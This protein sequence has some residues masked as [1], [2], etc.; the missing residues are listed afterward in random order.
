MSEQALRSKFIKG[1]GLAIDLMVDQLEDGRKE[2]D[3]RQQKMIN[4][5]WP[6]MSEIIKDAKKITPL[7]LSDKSTSQR[8]DELFNN[9]AKGAITFDEAKQYMSLISQGFE[10]SDL[11]ELNEK[12]ERLEGAK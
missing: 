2:I 5:L 3:P 11:I 7:N 6:L 1:A 10:M 8:L 9:V 4:L 12:L